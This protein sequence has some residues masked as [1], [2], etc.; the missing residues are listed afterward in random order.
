MKA[1]K[2]IV[3]VIALTFLGQSL[4][5]AQQNMGGVIQ[6]ERAV[7][8]QKDLKKKLGEENVGE[9]LAEPEG[10]VLPDTSPKVLIQKINVEGIT[11]LSN[12]EVR[13]IVA[14]FEGREL[15]LKEAQ[16]IANMLSEEYRKKGYLTSR[17]YIPSQK[18]EGGVLLI[19][20]IEGK[21]GSVEVRGNKY[22][23]TK[24]LK[25]KL[26]LKPGE[27]FDYSK[28]QKALIAIN[29]L[30]DRSARVVLV[31]GAER[32]TTDVV[33]DVKDSLP[34]HVG[35][36]Y[37][38]FGAREI[39][40]DRYAMTLEHNN[41]TGHDDKAFFKFQRSESD[42]MEL[43]QFRY[44]IPV[45]ATLEVGGYAVQSEL[46]SGKEFED[47]ESRGKAKLAGLFFSKALIQGQNLDL[48]LNGGYDHKD[49]V[50]FLYGEKQSRDELRVFKVGMDLD[51]TDSFGRNILNAEF[52]Q[53]FADIFG[54]MED[55]DPESSRVG[56]GAQFSKGLFNFYRLQPMPFSTL[57][58]W[59]NSAQ[60]SNHNLV[61]AE[62]FQVGGAV[63]VR[64]YAPGEF[65]GDRGYFS[66]LELTLPLYGLSK[67]VKVPF[68]Q[69]KLYD[70]WKLVTFWDFGYV[71]N[72]RTEIGEDKDTTVKGYGFGTH[73][74]VKD[75]VVSLEIGYPIGNIS[76]DGDHAHPW[77]EVT[78]KF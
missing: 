5:F 62:R 12:D 61:E 53:G 45:N 38:N 63:S 20:A 4:T 41:L 51:T 29:E 13:R 42:Y 77:V 36:G 26:N 1:I 50:N 68:C 30:P 3:A 2:V 47:L 18:I 39:E 25:G 16:K 21:V 23:S 34:V 43:Q 69:E 27:Y 67:H 65:A 24:L 10:V 55:K 46:E 78:Y 17:A 72:N 70:A 9:K 14:P 44:S 28:M 15:S 59:K 66:S 22:F 74:N 49:I 58:L 57:L 52:D 71:A 64:G 56:A 54:G 33:M 6:Q 7:K 19:R 73:F 75:L 31:P 32:G 40:K 35:F 8:K 76:S 48:T 60:Y 37:D 11:I